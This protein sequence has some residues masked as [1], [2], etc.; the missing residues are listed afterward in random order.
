MRGFFYVWRSTY[1]KSEFFY[2][3]KVKIFLEID[4][5]KVILGSISLTVLLLASVLST[6]LNIFV[7]F[8]NE[9]HSDVFSCSRR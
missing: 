9:G 7:K 5:L 4:I 6:F 2:C 3:L 8:L 1:R